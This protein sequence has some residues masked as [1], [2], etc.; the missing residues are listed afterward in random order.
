MVVLE[1][2]GEDLADSTFSLKIRPIWQKPPPSASITM[3]G[4]SLDL[5]NTYLLEEFR[6]AGIAAEG[7]ENRWLEVVIDA[8]YVGFSQ[9]QLIFTAT[10]REVSDRSD[11][12]RPSR[13]QNPGATR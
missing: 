10:L 13:R 4:L 8:Y 1:H 11:R 9:H 2:V 3:D 5:L 7:E 12:P 6:A